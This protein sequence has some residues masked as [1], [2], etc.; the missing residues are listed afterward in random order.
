VH[1]EK[2][3]RK[4][5]I[6]YIILQSNKLPKDSADLNFLDVCCSVATLKIYELISYMFEHPLD[7]TLVRDKCT[8]HKII[9]F[10]SWKCG[11]NHI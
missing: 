6:N 1:R 2:K 7:Y 3:M 10:Q 11:L 8:G 4:M 9:M 5:L